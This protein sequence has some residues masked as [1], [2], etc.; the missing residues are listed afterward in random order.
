MR[1]ATA[2][3]LAIALLIAACT[4]DGEL[5]PALTPS[6]T[7]TP[8]ATVA[9][10][11]TPTPT[12][13]I[14]PTKTP[15]PEQP[16]IIGPTLRSPDGSLRAHVEFQ[17]VRC[18]DGCSVVFED[19]RGTEL[20]RI[21]FTDPS[22]SRIADAWAAYSIDAWLDDSSGVV[23]GGSCECDAGGVRPVLLVMTD[24][25][26][27]DEGVSAQMLGSGSYVS[28]NGRYLLSRYD[29]ESWEVDAIGCHLSGSADVISL[30][31]GEMVAMIP[32]S[33]TAIIDWQWLDGR[34]LA[35]ALRAL[36]DPENG[37]CSERFR[38]WWD[39]PVEWHILAIP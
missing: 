31:S 9:V 6:P 8:E 39:L 34:T 32:P 22:L 21:H 1:L 14:S 15:S 3:L 23:L 25:S 20:L 4:G 10:G 36:P 26:V 5:T 17:F 18:P 33:E 16:P 12:A 29:I 2:A 7:P 28:P 27:I 37:R 35:Y 11:P 13:A 38:E 24:G 19:R 30:L